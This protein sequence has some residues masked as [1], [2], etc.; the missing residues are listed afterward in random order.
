MT[1]LLSHI[2]VRDIAET[3]LHVSVHRKC[4]ALGKNIMNR[5]GSQFRLSGYTAG[6]VN[7]LFSPIFVHSDRESAG[8]ENYSEIQHMRIVYLEHFTPR[9][10]NCHR[11]SLLRHFM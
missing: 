10:R 9:E 4:G 11:L 7:L 5:L 1:G 2:I 8:V 3:S 6:R